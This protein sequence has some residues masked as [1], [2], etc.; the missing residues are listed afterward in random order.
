MNLQV[1]AV[2]ATS[3]Y[4]TWSAPLLPYGNIVS[5]TVLIEEGLVGGN[6]TMLVGNSSLGTSSTVTDLLPFTYYNFSIAASTRIGTGP[7]DIISITTPQASKSSLLLTDSGPPVG[8]T[9][10]IYIS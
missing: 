5:Y 2:N 1:S 10:H 7:Y 3:V 4:L 6:V 8:F 9:V